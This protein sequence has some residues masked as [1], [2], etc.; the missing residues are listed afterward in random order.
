MTQGPGRLGP[1]TDCGGG[2]HPCSDCRRHDGC[3]AGGSREVSGALM[4][5]SLTIRRGKTLCLAG[6]AFKELYAI[7]S[8]CFKT[9]IVSE[10]GREQV[11]AFYMA[12][13]LI[14][15]DA[16]QTGWHGTTAIA[17]EDSQVCALPF[18][19][20]QQACREL[21]GLQQRLLGAMSS[22]IARSY[23][24]SLLLGN[25]R[26]EERVAA[27]LLD[28]SHRLAERGYSPAEFHLR[29]TREEI[30]SYLGLKLET[31]SRAF[32]KFQEMGWIGVQNK[33]VRLL[34]RAGLSAGAGNAPP[35]ARRASADRMGIVRSIVPIRL[36]A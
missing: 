1:A 34:D 4:S 14:G 3:L 8:G 5:S 31:V 11:T 28:L 36:A 25:M 2:R 22:E 32:S 10:D 21:P 18:A 27:F 20:L 6:D 23:G 24:V 30:G 33:H 17:L 12:G 35:H 9:C 7:R 15:L 16:I 29:M 26:A 19:R 13:D